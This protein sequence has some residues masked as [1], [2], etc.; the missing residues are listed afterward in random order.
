[1]IKNKKTQEN[2]M[3]RPT[4]NPI[5]LTESRLRKIIRNVIKESYF[6][7][8][9]PRIASIKKCLLANDGTLVDTVD[10]IGDLG[11]ACN[12]ES[13]NDVAFEKIGDALEDF[14]CFDSNLTDDKVSGK[15]FDAF[16][17]FDDPIYFTC[18]SNEEELNSLAHAIRAACARQDPNQMR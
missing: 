1:M 6:G 2:K 14:K 11:Y 4:R 15:N 16:M 12:G 8:K 3:R 13:P 10:L 9:D 7:Q 17:S 5:R 18:P